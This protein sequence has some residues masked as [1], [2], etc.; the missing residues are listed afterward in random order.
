MSQHLRASLV[1]RAESSLA[2]VCCLS[3]QSE[4]GSSPIGSSHRAPD[5]CRGRV[6][7]GPGVAPLTKP[8]RLVPEAPHRH[9]MGEAVLG[10]WAER[11]GC[12]ISG[13]GRGPRA[14]LEATLRLWCFAG[15]C[16]GAAAL[17]RTDWMLCSSWVSTAHPLSRAGL[18][19]SSVV[20][21]CSAAS[22]TSGLPV[23]GSLWRL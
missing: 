14:G 10:S 12:R 1:R 21:H 4:M 11:H 23:S 13:G 3:A 19:D 7:L 9:P 20:S 2:L 18:N 5:S 8:T 15:S 6:P 16:L 22:L 17:L